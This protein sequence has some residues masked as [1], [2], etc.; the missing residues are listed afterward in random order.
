MICPHSAAR[1][2]TNDGPQHECSL[3]REGCGV[4][5]YVP[6]E[7][8]LTCSQKDDGKNEIG[9]P[10]SFSIIKHLQRSIERDFDLAGHGCDGCGGTALALEESVARLKA[11]IGD[12]SADSLVAA[13]ANGL[14]IESAEAL[15]T[16]VFPELK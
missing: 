5:V 11:R 16:A 6:E 7:R 15:A 8:C 9:S 10:V 3:I 1:A 4:R 12:E 2:D 14:P 13:V